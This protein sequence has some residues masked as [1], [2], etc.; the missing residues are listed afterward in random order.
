MS[1]LRFPRRSRHLARELAE[2]LDEAVATQRSKEHPFATVLG[3][4]GRTFK[5]WWSALVGRS[6][7]TAYRE[8]AIPKAELL[9]TIEDGDA[10]ADVRL[11]AAVAVR[12]L[13]LDDIGR[14]RVRVAAQ[15]T[16]NPVLRIGLD[17]A[18]ADDEDAIASAVDDFCEAHR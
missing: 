13:G 8:I 9:A 7:D 16:R 2:R 4:G 10:P 6:P 17:R 12:R 15:L 3:R 11:G 14:A 1:C 18:A 5:D